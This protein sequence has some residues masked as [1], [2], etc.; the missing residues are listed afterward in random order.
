[1]K[2]LFLVL[3]TFLITSSH[4]KPVPKSRIPIT[5]KSPGDQLTSSVNCIAIKG[6]VNRT[7]IA[8]K[9]MMSLLFFIFVID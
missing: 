7:A 5:T 3:F 6:I 9:I 1:M 2:I 8:V 4:K